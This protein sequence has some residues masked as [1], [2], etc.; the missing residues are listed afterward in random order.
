[1]SVMSLR[2]I[3]L[4]V[5]CAVVV[6]AC[7]LGKKTRACAA[8][9]PPK[10]SDFGSCGGMLYHAPS[11]SSA[12]YT[13]RVKNTVAAPFRLTD[14]CVLLDGATLFTDSEMKELLPKASTTPPQW[15]GSVGNTRHTVAIQLVYKAN[16]SDFGESPTKE[17]EVFVRSAL[18]IAAAD[19]GELELVVSDTGKGSI[20]ERLVVAATLPKESSQPKCE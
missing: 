11:G 2:P 13:I 9:P 3:H 14:A 4:L 16:G 18:E 17:Y 6:P 10:A 7:M 8:L 12:V 15:T 20:D 19:G 5:L 1:M